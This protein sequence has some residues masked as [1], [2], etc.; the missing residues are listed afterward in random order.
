MEEWTC[1]SCEEVFWTDAAVERGAQF[2]PY[3]RAGNVASEGIVDFGDEEE[4][5]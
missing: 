4:A 2:C 5:Y 1:L 3:C